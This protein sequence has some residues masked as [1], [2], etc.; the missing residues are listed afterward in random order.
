MSAPDQ[1]E[2]ITTDAN[3]LVANIHDRMPAIPDRADYVR[4]LGEKE[5]P[6]ELMRSFPSDA[7]HLD[8]CQ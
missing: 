4:W 3:K 2:L 6:R 8:A 5:D 7:M 1:R